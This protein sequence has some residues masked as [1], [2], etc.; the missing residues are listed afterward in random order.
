MVAS[1]PLLI[2]P[3][4]YKHYLLPC[5]PFFAI[6]ANMVVSPCLAR[7]SAKYIWMTTAFVLMLSSGRTYWHFGSPGKDADQLSDVAAIAAVV[8]SADVPVDH[9]EFCASNYPRRA[10]L[11]RHHGLTSSST[12]N[13]V[14]TTDNA[15]YVVCASSQPDDQL[16]RVLELNDELALWIRVP[17]PDE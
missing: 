2:S 13:H 12:A 17:L 11:A 14:T 4:Q 10:Y 15:N 8:A 5:L 7:W 6:W 16:D 3:R 9:V 1:L